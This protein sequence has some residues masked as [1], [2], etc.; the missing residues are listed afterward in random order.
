MTQRAPNEKEEEPGILVGT[1]DR[2]DFQPLFEKGARVPLLAEIESRLP[3]AAKYLGK[4]RTF[5]TYDSSR[6]ASFMW[7]IVFS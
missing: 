4:S 3:T 6:F 7:C 1:S 5:L 2:L